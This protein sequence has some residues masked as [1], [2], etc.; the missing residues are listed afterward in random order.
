MARADRFLRIGIGFGL[1][2][3]TISYSSWFG[4]LVERKSY[5]IACVY[6]P[7]RSFIVLA[8]WLVALP[9]PMT[10]VFEQMPA[11]FAHAAVPSVPVR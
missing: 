2:R 7:L 5:S 6:I 9:L 4:F 11:L 3:I 8:S 1:C 10:Q